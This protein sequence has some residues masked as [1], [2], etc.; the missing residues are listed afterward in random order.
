M[1]IIRP[2]DQG[3]GLVGKYCKMQSHICPQQEAGAGTDF[4]A[5]VKGILKRACAHLF[6]LLVFAWKDPTPGS[7]QLG[8]TNFRLEAVEIRNHPSLKRKG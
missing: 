6:S 5:Q 4:K 2:K 3:P 1:P 8:M 7:F